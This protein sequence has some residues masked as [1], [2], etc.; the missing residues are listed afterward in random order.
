[1]MLATPPSCW[2]TLPKVWRTSGVDCGLTSLQ[3]RNEVTCVL[4][5]GG[6]VVTSDRMARAA[7][8]GDEKQLLPSGRLL[9]TGRTGTWPG[10]RC[11]PSFFPS[12]FL[13]QRRHLCLQ[14]LPFHSHAHS[15]NTERES[16]PPP[17]S[18]SHTQA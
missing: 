10:S 2:C 5:A 3:R 15:A 14:F 13:V 9:A 17:P 18:L 1:M 16:P 11:L 6:N 4:A 8:S 12:V 7:G